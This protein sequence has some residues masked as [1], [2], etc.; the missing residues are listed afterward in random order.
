MTKY[1][2]G[3]P[4]LTPLPFIGIQL[5]IF[6]YYYLELINT[7]YYRGTEFLVASGQ[8]ILPQAYSPLKFGESSAAID[9][10]RSAAAEQN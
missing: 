8:Y 4:Q 9:V 1:R 3:E 2:Q 6:F 5:N 7:N 10:K